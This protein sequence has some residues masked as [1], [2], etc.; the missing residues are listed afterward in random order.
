MGTASNSAWSIP[1][2]RAATTADTP[3]GH[4]A[5]ILCICRDAIVDLVPDPKTHKPLG[6][7]GVGILVGSQ[8][9][10][11]KLAKLSPSKFDIPGED[12]ASS[13]LLNRWHYLTLHGSEC[14]RNSDVSLL[15][16]SSTAIASV[17]HRSN[18]FCFRQSRSYENII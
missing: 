4:I 1:G 3:H 6:V 18:P 7:W 16:R 15:Q 12:S 10:A 8:G 11:G 9:A 5:R 2:L 14:H 13:E 17:A